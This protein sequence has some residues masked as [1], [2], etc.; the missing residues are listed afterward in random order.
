MDCFS[1]GSCF[2]SY[3]VHEIT[4]LTCYKKTIDIHLRS[5]LGSKSWIGL[6]QN[7]EFRDKMS[8][9]LNIDHFNY[10]LG[11]KQYQQLWC[12]KIW[13]SPTH[14]ELIS[15]AYNVR[16]VTPKFNISFLVLRI[17]L[18]YHLFPEITCSFQYSPKTMLKC[19]LFSSHGHFQRILKPM[20]LGVL[21]YIFIGFYPVKMH[22]LLL[23]IFWK[24][25]LNSSLY[26]A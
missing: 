9:R 18:H 26:F 17:F 7:R 4:Y 14:L 5:Q 10:V 11:W 24:W 15:K 2:Q 25:K 19:T 6:Q 13:I 3:F 8:K 12:F 20:H 22:A 21:F 1:K 16:H 23:C